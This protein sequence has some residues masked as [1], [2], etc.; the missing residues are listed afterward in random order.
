MRKTTSLIVVAIIF[1]NT[2][3]ATAVDYSFDDLVGMVYVV[4]NPD[5]EKNDTILRTQSVGNVSEMQTL[6]DFNEISADVYKYFAGNETVT[7]E[8]MAPV[9]VAKGWKEP[10]RLVS[11]PAQKISRL[12]NP[13]V[14]SQLVAG[15]SF[16][17]Q[18]YDPEEEATEIINAI[19]KQKDGRVNIYKNLYLRGDVIEQNV[20][21]K[22]IEKKHYIA[23][24][25][26]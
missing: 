11:Y 21:I 22:A 8:Q 4:E 25:I 17:T 24:A 16:V 1:I 2:M 23:V 6:K 14:S 15:T 7:A 3:A 13:K 12:D 18:V 10:I 9:Y 5:P 26:A 19:Y 20:R